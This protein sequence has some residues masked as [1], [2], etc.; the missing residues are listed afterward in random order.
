M[1]EVSNEQSIGGDEQTWND[2]PQVRTHR[3]GALNKW[4]PGSFLRSLTDVNWETIGIN[5]EPHTNYCRQYCQMK[6]FQ[7]YLASTYHYNCA[8]IVFFEKKK[9]NLRKNRRNIKTPGK[10][11]NFDLIFK[12]HIPKGNKTVLKPDSK[13]IQI[14]IWKPLKKFL[15]IFWRLEDFIIIFLGFYKSRSLQIR[16]VFFHTIKTRFYIEFLSFRCP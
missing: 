14:E 5:V 12:T 8:M 13:L 2:E 7:F 15:E 11:I 4:C 9:W 16:A 10:G 3:M 6:T 1:L